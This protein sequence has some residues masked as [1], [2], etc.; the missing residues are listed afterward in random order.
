M[1]NDYNGCSDP[2]YYDVEFREQNP[3]VYGNDEL[4]QSY[5]SSCR[6][7]QQSRLVRAHRPTAD[8]ERLHRE[9]Q[10]WKKKN[11][12]RVKLFQSTHCSHTRSQNDA[13]FHSEYEQWRR[14]HPDKIAFFRSPSTQSG[15]ASNVKGPASIWP[16]IIIGLI[17]WPIIIFAILQACE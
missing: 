8:D 4:M 12:E 13:Q 16:N 15:G 11:P 10:Q 14:N 17:I 9:Y 7:G 5:R 1:T 2:D 6:R 3:E